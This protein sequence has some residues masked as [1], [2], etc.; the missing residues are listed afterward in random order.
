MTPVIYAAALGQFH[1]VKSLMNGGANINAQDKNGWT[2]LHW[3]ADAGLNMKEAPES[4][5][6]GN[7]WKTVKAIIKSGKADLDI[8]NRQGLVLLSFY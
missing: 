6:K 4:Q 2:A 5:K 1:A 7:H 8:Q 3:A